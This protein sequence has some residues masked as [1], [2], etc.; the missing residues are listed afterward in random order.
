MPPQWPDLVLPPNIPN[1]EVDVLVLNRLDVETDGWDCRDNLAK[2]EL[3][4]NGGLPR[5]V[6]P[7]CTRWVPGEWGRGMRGVGAGRRRA[8]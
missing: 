8:G 6:K 3:V 7:D 4:K 5:S 2:L 1:R